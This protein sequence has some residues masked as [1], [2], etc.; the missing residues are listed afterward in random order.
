MLHRENLML[1]IP[2]VFVGFGGEAILQPLLICARRR[3]DPCQK[4][5]S[6]SDSFLLG[7]SIDIFGHTNVDILLDT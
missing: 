2:A 4:V 5:T 3:G 6:Y 7:D 1:M